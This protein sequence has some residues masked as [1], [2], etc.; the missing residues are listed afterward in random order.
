LINAEEA[1]VSKP[2]FS[3]ILRRPD[4]RRLWFGQVVS[5]IGTAIS[6]LA[7]LFFA[8]YLTGS[9]LAMAILSIAR[10]VPVVI[11]SGF[12]GVYVDR[13]DRK[14]I[15]VGSDLLRTILILLIPLSIHFPQNVPTI[16]WVYLLTFLY[17]SVDAWFY[18]A[19][20]ASIPNLVETEELVTA[21]SLSQMTFQ[22][23]QLTI[24]PLGGALIAILAPDYFLA[25]AIN[26]ITFVISA[27]SL[28]GIAANLK[29]QNEIAEK[30]RLMEQISA[31]AKV[32]IQNAI[33]SFI[34]V[35]AILLAVSSGIL[36]ALLLPHL[37]GSLGLS[38][39]DVGLIMGVGAG[40]GMVAAIYLG[41]KSDLKRPL[42]LINIAGIIAGIAV[43]GFSLSDG[44]L[45]VVLSWMIIAS[46]DVILNIPLSVIMQ[47][48]VADE[49]RGRVFSLLSIAFTSFQVIG[50]GLG[51]VWAETIGSTVL[52]L[53]A[54]GLAFFLV[55]IIAALYLKQ[56]QLSSRLSLMLSPS[57][58]EV[59]V[60]ARTA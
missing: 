44:F 46:V 51:G 17:A 25:F 20:N 33:L 27:I 15:M 32:V 30:E 3:T 49:M 14:K 6:S 41:K 36:N 29:P 5:N 31:G 47:R 23:I 28:V 2:G 16:Y 11:F 38:E 40:V 19:R 39:S 52:P 48:L 54:S 57:I 1:E 26:S 21:N 34:F 42:A 24:P 58:E 12:I 8:Y 55:S 7:L 4:Y 18:P 10:V 45:G 60:V 13:W 9:A 37:Q 43:I 53:F 22:L 59:S 35:F 50:M 56:S